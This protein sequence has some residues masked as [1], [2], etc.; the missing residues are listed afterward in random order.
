MRRR[1]L[2]PRSRAAVL[3]AGLVAAGSGAGAE[4]GVAGPAGAEASPPRL[5]VLAVDGAGRVIVERLLAAG[6]LPNFAR[7]RRE[8][9]FSDG[10]V[11]AVPSRTA[12][13]F[14]MLWN[15]LPGAET[16]ITGNTVLAAPPGSHSLLDT[17]DGFSA[18]ALRTRPLW[19]RAAAAGRRAVAVH[20]TH[21][22]PIAEALAGLDASARERL[23]LL[24]GYTD[25]R[26]PP[27]TLDEGRNPLLA[28]RPP[29][30]C[31][32]GE[33]AGFFRFEVGETRFLGAFF[34]DPTDPRAGW[35][36]FAV[37]SDTGREGGGGLPGSC[38]GPGSVDLP[39]L[40]LARVRVGERGSFSIPIAAEASANPVPGSAAGPARGRA[41]F[42]VRAFAARPPAPGSPARFLVFRGGASGVAAWPDSD[43]RERLG[44]PY[45]G[46]SI[47]AAEFAAGRLGRWPGAGE[48][49]ASAA[50]G[51]PRVAVT[52]L[53]EVVEALE[54]TARAHLEAAADL[55]DWD[56]LALYLPFADE[57]GHLVYGALD[58]GLPSH[59]PATAAALRPVFAGAFAAVDR[60]LG[61]AFRIAEAAEAHLLVFGDHGMAGTDRRAHLNVA[62]ERAG[63]FAFAP[64]G[65]PDLARTRVLLLTTG[66]GSL[67]VN[68]ASRPGGV[69]EPGADEERALREAREAL[70]ALRTPEG[71]PVVLGFLAPTAS[72]FLRFGGDTTGD[73][74]PILRPGF[75]S[76]PLPSPEVVTAAPPAGSHGFLP[77]RP[78]MQAVLA[79]WGPRIPPGAWPRASALAVLP[80]ALDLLGLPPD[81]ALP[82]RSLLGEPPLVRPGAEGKAVR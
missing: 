50:S 57:V 18:A 35:D 36:T 43:W 40:F 62:L 59:D 63:L 27:A 65:S 29:G 54:E 55:P 39:P 34:D 52:R 7:L 46:G 17:A 42:R 13:S 80:T 64:D 37:L 68:R 70:L 30:G 77:V 69:V 81:P 9:A 66:D 45:Y 19:A 8:G 15:G 73:L 26:I 23:F 32:F 61:D 79:A 33:G 1:S 4:A 3:A 24:T 14:A 76:S 58:E 56:L 53:L 28:G 22:F 41:D 71:D 49:V 78:D 67:A 75:R 82:G 20:T 11:P 25:R 5:V 44:E 16:G 31:G 74:F 60:V 21:T 2:G 48:E 6:A 12:P 38:G 47:G 72:G 10:L 51:A